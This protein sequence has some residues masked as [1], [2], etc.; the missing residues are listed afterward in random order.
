VETVYNTGE[1]RTVLTPADHTVL[2]R[3]IRLFG[4]LVEVEPIGEYR[5][6]TPNQVWLTLVG[7]VCVRGSAR[8]MERLRSDPSL[9]AEFEGAVSLKAMNHERNVVSYLTNTFRDFSATRFPKRGAEYLATLL[10][11]P[12]VFHKDKLV[13]FNQLSHKAS[14]VQTRDELI[15]R[16]PIFRLK[17]ASDFMIS[18]GLSHDVIALDTRVVGTLQKHLSYNLTPAR[19]Q[20]QRGLYL[21]L[22]VAL[23]NF[24]NEQNISLALLDRILF[25][26]SNMG[27]IDLIVKYPEVRSSFG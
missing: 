6:M 5:T 18:V 23:R 8:H 16:C 19:I 12:A 11:F 13:L 9:R 25:K 3:I 22:E 17:S 14:A 1:I 15:K 7:E 4:K 10:Q 2:C 27:A 26:F 20:S 21:S 24:C